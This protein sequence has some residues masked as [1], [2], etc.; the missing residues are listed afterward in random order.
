[1]SEPILMKG[2]EAFCEAAMRGGARYY[3]GYPITP[4][5]EIPEY[6]AAHMDEILTPFNARF[7]RYV[8]ICSEL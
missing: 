2:N 7:L 3:F 5:S 8:C 1:M 4:Q 6:M